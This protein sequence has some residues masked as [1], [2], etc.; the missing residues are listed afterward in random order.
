[1]KFY[2]NFHVPIIFTLYFCLSH[3]L[4]AEVIIQDFLQTSINW[5]KLQLSIPIK[6][7]TPKI[8]VSGNLEASNQ[9][10][11]NI[12]E[13]RTLALNSAKEKISLLSVRALEQLQFDNQYK[14]IDIIN[15]NFRF[16]KSFNEFILQENLEYK[17]RINE[18][19]VHVEAVISFLGR[20]GV[21]NYLLQEYNTEDIPNISEERFATP[22]TGL[23]L[24]ARHLEAKPALFPKILTEKGLEIYSPKLV[25]KNLALDSGYA[26]YYNK[27]ESAI[28]DKKVG[29]KPYILLAQSV[30]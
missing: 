19:E 26:K 16:R 25:Y 13:A 6:E 21:F 20:Y 24:D 9:F 3:F 23:I 17:V 28:K 30:L 2:K 27:L 15:S 18:D 12:N 1:M 7:R 10:A 8:Q 11:N 14:I 4:L 5:T 29:K 22:Y